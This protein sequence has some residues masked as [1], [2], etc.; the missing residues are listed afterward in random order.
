MGTATALICPKI[1]GPEYVTVFLSDE[2]LIASRE[3][4]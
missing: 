4:I 3:P 1:A 2:N